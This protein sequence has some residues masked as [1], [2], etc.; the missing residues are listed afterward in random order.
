M[1]QS[2]FQAFNTLWASRNEAFGRSLSMNAIINAFNVLKD[3]DL[4]I[5]SEAL[6]EHA[7]TSSFPPLVKDVLDYARKNVEGVEAGVEWVLAAWAV[8]TFGPRPVCFQNVR[9][10]I[11]INKMG[12]Y[13]YLRDNLNEKNEDYRRKEFIE[14]FE[15]ISSVSKYPAEMKFCG[16]GAEQQH[17]NTPSDYMAAWVWYAGHQKDTYAHLHIRNLLAQL[18]SG[19]EKIVPSQDKPVIAL[20]LDASY[21]KSKVSGLIT[22]TRADADTHPGQVV[23]KLQ[24]GTYLLKSST[25]NALNE[26]LRAGRKAELQPA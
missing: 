3:L 10:A 17:I 15:S 2:E 9:T 19:A 11:T 14:I 7:K 26:L 20:G 6:R 12:G 23:G 25:E 24:D 4:E 18:E 1:Q 22:G 16:T 21:Y 8:D 5:I 13:R